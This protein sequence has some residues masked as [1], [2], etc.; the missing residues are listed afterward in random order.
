MKERIES[1]A[2]EPV[3]SQPLANTV[4]RLDGAEKVACGLSAGEKLKLLYAVRD[5][6]AAREGK[7]PWKMIQK[8][9]GLPGKGN[10]LA[11]KLCFRSFV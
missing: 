10:R 3:L 4:W 6:G 8:E 5:S 11:L 2:E 7:I 1:D 9:D